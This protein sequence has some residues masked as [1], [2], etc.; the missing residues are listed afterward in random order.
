MPGYMANPEDMGVALMPKGNSLSLDARGTV[1]REGRPQR[2]HAS[3]CGASRARPAIPPS[4]ST[5]HYLSNT[6]NQI[7]ESAPRDDTGA[8]GLCSRARP[9][10]RPAGWTSD[11]FQTAFA[12]VGGKPPDR[13]AL[14]GGIRRHDR[15]TSPPTK[16]IC[17]PGNNQKTRFED[18]Q[19]ACGRQ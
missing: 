18:I 6:Q 8:P 3:Y 12:A 1:L 9:H 10:V 16:T 15:T 4:L 5:R 11:V 19:K 17:L 2:G 13:R 14:G 7:M